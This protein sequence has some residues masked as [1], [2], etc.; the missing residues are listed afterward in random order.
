MKFKF[1]Q[2]QGINN[3][4]VLLDDKDITNCV[5][6]LKVIAN[7]D[8]ITN[9]LIDIAPSDIEIELEDYRLTPNDFT[10]DDMLD[11]FKKD[12]ASKAKINYIA[13]NESKIEKLKKIKNKFE[14][15]LL[16]KEIESGGGIV[17][18]NFNKFKQE[19]KE[20]C[21]YKGDFEI[22]DLILQ[23]LKEGDTE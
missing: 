10:I 16:S 1:K 4:K 14:K 19:C 21:A 17:Y 13:K 2:C 11:A 8:D 6:N 20:E 9:V 12:I 7:A 3:V 22:H 23:L 15:L 5:R 18:D